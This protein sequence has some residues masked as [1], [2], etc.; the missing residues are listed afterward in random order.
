MDKNGKSTGTA[1]VALESKDA[2]M[3]AIHRYHNKVADG[4]F[5]TNTINLN[6]LGRVLKVVYV[7][8]GLSIAGVARKQDSHRENISQT[9]PNEMTSSASI[10]M[11]SDRMEMAGE[12]S[13][14]SRLTNMVA[15]A[16]AAAVK[17]VQQ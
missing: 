16:A 4:I 6:F 12:I 14:P 8:P 7:E 2:A 17:S 1:K 15:M 9:R 10:G 13:R 5:L 11:Y 3:Q